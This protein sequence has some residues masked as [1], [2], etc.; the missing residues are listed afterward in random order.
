[1]IERK[2]QLRMECENCESNG[3]E[4]VWLECDRIFVDYC[5]RIFNLWWVQKPKKDSKKS[6]AVMDCNLFYIQQ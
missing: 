4:R 5:E 3:H 6:V 1:M 2:N